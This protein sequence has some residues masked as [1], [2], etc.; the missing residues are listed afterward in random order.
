M[1]AKLVAYILSAAAI[2]N[3]DSAATEANYS[4]DSENSTQPSGVAQGGDRYKWTPTDNYKFTYTISLGSIRLSMFSGAGSIWRMAGISDLPF[5]TPVQDDDAG[6]KIVVTD[7][8]NRYA[9]LADWAKGYSGATS[10]WLAKTYVYESSF[11]V[12]YTYYTSSSMGPADTN[13]Q[14]EADAAGDEDI[15]SYVHSLDII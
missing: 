3:S 13:E 12:T 8:G 2:E 11:D 15:T 5:S 9:Y 4:Y 1:H 14:A 7:G 6:S 10:P